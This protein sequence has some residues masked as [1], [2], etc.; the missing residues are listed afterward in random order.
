MTQQ[1][2]GAQPSSQHFGVLWSPLGF[3]NDQSKR[4]Y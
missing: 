4:F 2:L 1:D 3:I